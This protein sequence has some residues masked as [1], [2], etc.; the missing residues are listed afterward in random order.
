MNPC[1]SYLKEIFK[2]I[3]GELQEPDKKKL[4]THFDYWSTCSKHAQQLKDL[5][6]HLCNLTPQ[7]A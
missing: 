5:K 6:F 2:F 7:K 4:M 1:Q 3:D